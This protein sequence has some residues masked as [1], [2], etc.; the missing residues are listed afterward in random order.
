MK[1]LGFKACLTLYLPQQLS[2]ARNKTIGDLQ[3]AIEQKESKILGLEAK[4][5]A[6]ESERQRLNNQI[7]EW[8][9]GFVIL[10]LFLLFMSAQL[11]QS[12]FDS[13]KICLKKKDHLN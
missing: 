10:K 12:S 3:F 1:T 8:K 5:R 9:V 7:E 2:E 4:A 13:M 11:M 6:H